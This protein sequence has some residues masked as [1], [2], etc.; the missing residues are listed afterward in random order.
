LLVRTVQIVLG[1]RTFAVRF[2]D[3]IDHLVLYLGGR[4]GIVTSFID[5][6]TRPPASGLVVSGVGT[7]LT[8]EWLERLVP[9][10]IDNLSRI[11]ATDW[12]A[13]DLPHFQAPTAHRAQ[14]ALWQV[15]WWARWPRSAVPVEP[16]GGSPAPD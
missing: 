13:A 4:P 11:R 5:D 2:G 7:S 10:F 8:A 14:P 3:D 9:Q 12:R 15:N 6:V 16:V 1:E